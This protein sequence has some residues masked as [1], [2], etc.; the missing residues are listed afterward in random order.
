MSSVTNQQNQGDPLP[1]F[2]W[3]VKTGRVIQRT[4]KVRLWQ[5]R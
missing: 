2:I 3:M 4:E 1:A 5:S